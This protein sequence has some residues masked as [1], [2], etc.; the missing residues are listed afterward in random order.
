MKDEIVEWMK[1]E[2][3][4]IL[5]ILFISLFLIF[6]FHYFQVPHSDF[7]LYHYNAKNLE[8]INYFSVTN[9]QKLPLYSLIMTPFSGRVALDVCL[10][11]NLFLYP[12]LIF[13]V[14]RL[15]QEY[16]GDVTSFTAAIFFGVNPISIY[17]A[18]Q[19]L[20]FVLF[21]FL[22][23]SSFLLTS[24]E[25]K[26]SSLFLLNLT[27]YESIL[28]S[29]FTFLK[30]FFEERKRKVLLLFI[31]SLSGLGTWV[32]LSVHFTGKPPFITGEHAFSFN[33]G[34][35]YYLL[36]VTLFEV[37]DFQV[38]KALFY[39]M[40]LFACY[41]GFELLRKKRKRVLPIVLFTL[42]YIV[43]HTAFMKG[44]RRFVF[45]VLPF[46]Y[47]FFFNGIEELWKKVEL[48]EDKRRFLTVLLAGIL[49]IWLIFSLDFFSVLEKLISSYL[50]FVFAL[51]ISAILAFN[52]R[53]NKTKVLSIVIIIFVLFSF[54][55]ASIFLEKT[56]SRKAVFRKVG[57][58]SSD[59]KL[60]GKILVTQP[61]IVDFY[62]TKSS[63]KLISTQKMGFDNLSEASE[64]LVE[65]NISYVVWTS[66]D[67][68]DYYRSDI[69]WNMKINLVASLNRTVPNF[70]KSVQRISYEDERGIIFKF[71]K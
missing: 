53:K 58:W 67:N 43:L 48:S 18:L 44:F 29:F 45:I 38:M 4:I 26:Y 6:N 61:H 27:R 17:L 11:L 40:P 50:F 60:K 3:E 10:I 34:F 14:Y 63:K 19:P 2:K 51:A 62:S 16:L 39:L 12:F 69:Y 54:Y 30:D 36:N 47:L 65:K 64:E 9:F 57:E 55:N 32:Y 24:R 70:L 66:L 5:A 20:P 35:L 41:G 37:V 8:N 33:K 71:K 56:D 59:N 42:S 13:L 1:S 21:E 15:C 49:T 31:L 23:V 7:F 28:A 25:K 68:K 52:C 46:I 22:L